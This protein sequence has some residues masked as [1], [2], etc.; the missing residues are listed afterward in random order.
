MLLEVIATSVADAVEAERGG[1]SRIELVR[2][3]ARG[4]LTP[5]LDLVQDVL[6]AVT[7]PVRVMLRSCDGFRVGSAAEAARLEETAGELARLSVDGL[8]LG[9]VT[10]DGAVDHGVTARILAAAPNFRATFHHAF[11]ALADRSTGLAALMAMPTIDRVLAHGGQG[12][13]K[14]KLDRLEALQA[15]AGSRLTMLV[16]GGV[17]E[18]AARLIA[19]RPSLREVHVGRLVREPATTEGRVMASRVA[20]LRELLAASDTPARLSVALRTRQR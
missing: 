15:T 13:W 16:G 4:G 11:E 2:D 19:G 12:T 8:V 5:P 6:S 7:I 20:M 1:A 10:A 3:L 14:E 9:W 18:E 17:T